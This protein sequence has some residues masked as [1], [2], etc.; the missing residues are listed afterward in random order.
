MCVCVAHWQEYSFSFG[1]FCCIVLASWWL[2]SP[3]ICVN[4]W[5]F[6]KRFSR[7]LL[8]KQFQCPRVGLVE[9]FFRRSMS[10]MLDEQEDLFPKQIHLLRRDLVLSLSPRARIWF[11]AVDV[12][13]P[14]LVNRYG[15]TEFSVR[16][17]HFTKAVVFVESQVIHR[18]LLRSPE[19]HSS[20]FGT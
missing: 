12:L 16:H 18:K 15:E 17:E 13:V 9:F 5:I 10:I 3:N 19:I 14:I 20:S 8:N 1:S 11:T 7:D 2:K 6:H 4:K